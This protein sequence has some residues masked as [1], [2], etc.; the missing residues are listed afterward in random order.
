MP[1]EWN[2]QSITHFADE[3]HEADFSRGK[4]TVRLAF[5]TFD[6]GFWFSL[7]AVNDLDEQTVAQFLND[8]NVVLDETDG[9]RGT[10]WYTDEQIGYASADSSSLSGGSLSPFDEA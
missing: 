10:T 8:L 9:L 1:K 6:R 7:D 2:L 3:Q 4:G 5:T